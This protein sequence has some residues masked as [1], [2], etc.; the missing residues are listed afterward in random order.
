VKE[1]GTAYILWAL[2]AVGLCGMHRLYAGKIGTG[3]LY[4][5]TFGLLGMGQLVDAFL[6]PRMVEDANNRLALEGVDP[7]MVGLGGGL[8][9][10]GGNRPPRPTE[11]LQVPLVQAA[12]RNQGKLTV[13]EAVKETGRGFT[14]VKKQLDAMAVNGFI[15]LDSDDDGNAFYHFPGL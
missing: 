1:K 13:P 8:G 11:V 2:G 7:S 4:F 14:E 6:I 15:E 10:L 12:E 3:L 5:F 9:L